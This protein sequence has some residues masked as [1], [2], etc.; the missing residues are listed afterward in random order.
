MTR[1]NKLLLKSGISILGVYIC[2]LTAINFYLNSDQLKRQINRQNARN[3][4]TYSKAYSLM[5]F[6][7]SVSGVQLV[8]N[9]SKLYHIKA[10]TVSFRVQPFHLLDR[11]IVLHNC[12]VKGIEYYRNAATPPDD[13][14]TEK[15]TESPAAEAEKK[16][17]DTKKGRPVADR[18]RKKKNATAPITWND[19]PTNKKTR[20]IKQKDKNK[21]SPDKEPPVSKPNKKNWDLS[22]VGA[23]LREIRTISIDDYCLV[24]HGHGSI[25]MS[26][27]GETM[28]IPAGKLTFQKGKV[29]QLSRNQIVAEQFDIRSDYSFRPFQ[30]RKVKGPKLFKYC[31]ATI[32]IND[33]H[34]SDLSFLQLY[35][36]ESETVSINGGSGSLKGKI[37]IANAAYGVGSNLSYDSADL[38]VKSM[39]DTFRGDGTV[40]WK[41]VAHDGQPR[42]ELIVQFNR[43]GLYRDAKPHVLGGYNEIKLWGPEVIIDQPIQD[44][45]ASLTIDQAQLP[46]L[47]LYNVYLPENIALKINKGQGEFSSSFLLPD[48]DTLDHGKISFQTSRNEISFQNITLFGDMTIITQ[49]SRSSLP[50]YTFNLLPSSLSLENITIRNEADLVARDWWGKVSITRGYLT[51]RQEQTVDADFTLDTRDLWPVLYIYLQIKDT[52]PDFLAQSLKIPLTSGQ[53][54]IVVGKDFIEFDRFQLEGK[55][56]SVDAVFRNQQNTINGAVML[57]YELTPNNKIRAGIE[58][59]DKKQKVIFEKVRD[60]FHNYKLPK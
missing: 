6:C 20:A 45:S 17:P 21:V 46:D 22:L 52:L 43:F 24:G 31:V 15:S 16:G 48:K 34:C 41:I 42:W 8:K 28:S 12:L 32:E 7:F 33:I 23:R 19:P 36:K 40:R 5:P 55:K 26:I 11:K 27:E 10:A 35:L 1:L 51:P 30:H 49:L 13:C 44:F 4:I 14:T 53:G 38:V 59:K 56:L 9:G 29:T 2:Y 25:T 50:E 60:W 37:N 3:T 54:H 18:P 39:D 47:S 58:L 57:A